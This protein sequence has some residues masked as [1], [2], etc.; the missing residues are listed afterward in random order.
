MQSIMANLVRL[1]IEHYEISVT[2]IEPRQMIASVFGVK[3]IFIH[4]ECWATG[5]WCVA[6]VQTHNKNN[7]WM[8]DKKLYNA[9]IKNAEAFGGK[10]VSHD[11]VKKVSFQS[12]FKSW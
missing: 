6:T 12:L 10:N 8:N 7:E 3:N 9:I 4:N 11:A 5:L 1:V 2:Y